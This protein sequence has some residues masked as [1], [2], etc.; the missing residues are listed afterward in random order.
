METPQIYK[1]IYYTLFFV[2][3]N[4]VKKRER[5]RKKFVFVT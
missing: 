4:K 5:E 2:I 1:Y 3:V